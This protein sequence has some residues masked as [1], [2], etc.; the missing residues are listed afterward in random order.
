MIRR[1]CILLATLALVVGCGSSLKSTEPA[2]AVAAPPPVAPE[3]AGA[4][5]AAP[6]D[7]ATAPAPASATPSCPDGSSWNGSRCAGN[8]VLSHDAIG[9]GPQ[10]PSGGSGDSTSTPLQTLTR[11]NVE[12]SR[13]AEPAVPDNLG[14]GPLAGVWV[15][16]FATRPGCSD[17]IVIRQEGSELQLSGADCNSGQRYDFQAARFAGNTLTVRSASGSG[18]T[19]ITYTLRQTRPGELKGKAEVSGGGEKRSYDVT[20]A[21]SSA[22]QPSAPAP[23]TVAHPGLEG[24]WV[25]SFGSRAGCSDKIAIHQVGNTLSFSGADCNDGNPYIYSEVSFNG[26]VLAVKVT[27]PSTRY[28]IRYNLRQTHPG[29]LKGRATVTGAGTTNTY[30]VTWKRQD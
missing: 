25:E 14:S 19:L 7:N 15:E 13:P 26:I 8:A 16:S 22:P 18:S 9:S 27:V 12:P 3:P 10:G 28:V 6:V 17:K 1:F 5:G 23:A 11:E 2:T 30:D 20:W 21:R 24:V 29:E 4:Q